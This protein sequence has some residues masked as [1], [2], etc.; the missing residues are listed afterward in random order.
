MNRFWRALPRK[1]LAI[2]TFYLGIAILITFPLITQLSTRMAGDESSDVYEMARHI[3]WFKHALQTGQ[4]LFDQPLLGYPEGITGVS[5][6]ADPL[7]F[8]PGWLF[9]FFMPVAAAYNLMT[10]LILALNGWA[11]YTLAAYLLDDSGPG[12]HLPALLSGVVFMTFPTFQGHLLGGH[13]GLLVMWPVPLYL[14]SLFHL[15]Q[16]PTRRWFALAAAFFILSP[17]GHALQLIYVLMPI[18]GMVLLALALRREWVNVGRVLLVAAFGGVGLLVFLL[19]VI[20]ETVETTAYTEASTS[21]VRYSADLLGIVSPS[22]QHPFFSALS[23]PRRVL[24]TNLVEGSTYIGITAAL[25]A[26]TAIWQQKAA[27][28]WLGLAA[29]AW[30]LSLGTLLKVYDTPVVIESGG[31]ESHI[32]LPFALVQNL[33]FFNLARTPGRFTFVLALAVA[34]L[35]GYGVRRVLAGRW[36]WLRFGF[37]AAVIIWEY[38]FFWPLPSVPAHIPSAVIALNQREDVRAVFNVPWENLL[39]AKDALYLQTGH[40]KPMIAGHVTRQT[41]VNPAKLWLLQ[42]TLDLALLDEANVDVIIVHKYWDDPLAAGPV[43][44]FTREKLG[45]PFYEDDRLALFNVPPLAAA[46]EFISLPSAPETIKRA[47]DTYF[48]LPQPGWLDF[49][50][51]VMGSDRV[52]RLYLDGQALHEWQINGTVSLA[53]GLPIPARGYH[54]LTLALD[55]PCPENFNSTLVCNGVQRDSLTLTPYVYGALYDPVQLDKGVQ[56]ISS[57]LDTS[58]PPGGVFRV[59]LW[60]LFVQPRAAEDVRFVHV[61]D[62]NGANV[63]QND[64][65]LGVFMARSG[66]VERVDIPL[67]DDLPAGEYTVYAGWYTTPDLTRFA[68]LANT[69]QAQN[70][71][72]YLGTFRVE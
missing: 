47:L 15:L 28:W 29:L 68:V 72:V 69:P 30:L 40:Q 71:L 64:R 26:L 25:L 59:D 58:A 48:Y 61:L 63:A 66:W 6:W 41:P 12:A 31:Y 42:N 67:P 49:S 51:V 57:A 60:W 20:K 13:T 4:P 10:L 39:A 14:Y 53:L 56:L 18:T 11:M 1:Q 24:G 54:T 38:Q 8:F 52:L 35:V 62:K 37:L 16:N 2:Y 23:Y 7:Q 27:R 32:P 36:R 19:P 17:T 33:P 50:A 65:P 55:P 21:V 45:A 43:E 44:S 22:F 3:W 46:P 9:A 5:L 70:G 34:A